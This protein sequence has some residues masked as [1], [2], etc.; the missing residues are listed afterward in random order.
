MYHVPPV[1]SAG[2]RAGCMG[3]AVGDTR[4]AVDSIDDVG[5]I[6]RL[7]GMIGILHVY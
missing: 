5:G 7:I 1:S 3:D 2:Q 4:S 6:G